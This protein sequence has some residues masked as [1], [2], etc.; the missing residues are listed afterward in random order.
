MIPLVNTPADAHALARAVK[1]HPL[2]QCDLD[3]HF[4]LKGTA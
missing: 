2:S 3:G 4:Y 1:F